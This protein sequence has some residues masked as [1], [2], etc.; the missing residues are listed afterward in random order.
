M[1]EIE[2]VHR[3]KLEAK[4]RIIAR[5]GAQPRVLD[6]VMAVAGV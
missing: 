2:M 5:Y 6:A 3:A 1:N 4:K